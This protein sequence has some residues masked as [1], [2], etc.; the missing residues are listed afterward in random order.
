MNA[1]VFFGFNPRGARRAL[2]VGAV[3]C[4][5]LAAWALANA[6]LGAERLGEARAGAA[7]GLAIAFAYALFRLRPR[8]GWGIA[9]QP[10]ALVVARPFSG[11]PL[12][13]AW[14]SVSLVRRE[15][16]GSRRTLVVFLKVGG[17]VLIPQHLFAD[18]SAFDAA[19]AAISARVEP[20]RFDA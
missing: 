14:S 4:V 16:A 10:L 12:E 9:L 17:R 2:W 11:E 19:V 13:L 7:G 1:E 20:P 3:A 18:A 6:R 5:A 8:P 15:G